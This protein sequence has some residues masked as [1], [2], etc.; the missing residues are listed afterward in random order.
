MA[1]LPL[2]ANIS[3]QTTFTKG[4]RSIQ[5]RLGD[6]YSQHAPDGLNPV[7]WRGNIVYDNMNSTDFATLITFLDTIGS[8][9]T[10]DYQPP[11]ASSTSKFSVDPAG[12]SISISAGNIY[13]VQFACRNEW[14][15]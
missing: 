11:G 7:E 6:G 3:Q 5:M 2:Q 10:F 15:I 12:P 9:G 4:Y 8:W 13:S 1:A 14:D